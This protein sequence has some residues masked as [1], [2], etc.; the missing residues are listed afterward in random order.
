MPRIKRP[1]LTLLL[2]STLSVSISASM[3]ISVVNNHSRSVLRVEKMD[4]VVRVDSEAYSMEP[5]TLKALAPFV[6]LE[7]YGEGIE[8]ASTE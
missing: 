7:K 6:Q 2:L 3:A 1:I 5:S 4:P 8:L